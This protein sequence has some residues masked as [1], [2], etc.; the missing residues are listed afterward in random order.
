MYL[1]FYSL[2]LEA[3][4][5]KRHRSGNFVFFSEMAA[6]CSG[7]SHGTAKSRDVGSNPT[8]VSDI[9][10]RAVQNRISKNGNGIR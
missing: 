4:T 2:Y 7:L 9:Y 3:Q 6:W 1:G 5:H 8:T 10:I